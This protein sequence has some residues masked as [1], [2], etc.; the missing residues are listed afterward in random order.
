MMGRTCLNQL[1]DKE[2]FLV[3]VSPSTDQV[4]DIKQF[5]EVGDVNGTFK[6]ITII[7]YSSLSL[8]FVWNRLRR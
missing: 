1:I 8:A 2:K 6:F 5:M 3:P 4:M 7:S